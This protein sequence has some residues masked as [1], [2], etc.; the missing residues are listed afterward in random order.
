MNAFSEHWNGERFKA[1]LRA[2]N[3]SKLRYPLLMLTFLLLAGMAITARQ[4][5]LG[6]LTNIQPMLEML[7]ISL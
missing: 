6:I 4:L 7:D 3:H 5:A 1:V 2:A